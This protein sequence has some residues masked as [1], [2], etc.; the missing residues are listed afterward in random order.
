MTASTR[1]TQV[2]SLLAALAA[3]SALAACSQAPQA[4]AAAT[5]AAAAPQASGSTMAPPATLTQMDS[6]SRTAASKIDGKCAFDSI[7]GVPFQVDTPANVQDPAAVKL[8]GWVADESTMTRPQPAA[9]RLESEDHSNAWQIA[10]G[11]PVSRG[12][13]AK[14]FKADGLANAGYSFPVNLKALP[15]GQYHLSIMHSQ[16]GTLLTCPGPTIQIS[17]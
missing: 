11:A 12:D 6:A 13:V 1:V 16:G 17:G 14:F 3:G 9:L 2:R 15:P 5:P 10:L 7:D 8:V 4:P